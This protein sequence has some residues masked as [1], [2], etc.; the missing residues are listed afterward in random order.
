[1]KKVVQEIIKKC[2]SENLQGITLKIFRVTKN[3]LT[4]QLHELVKKDKS[5]EIWF[6]PVPSTHFE[7]SSHPKNNIFGPR[8]TLSFGRDLEFGIQLAQK[9]NVCVSLPIAHVSMHSLRSAQGQRQSERRGK[10]M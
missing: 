2:I 1:M 4:G 6:V 10:Q 8:K 7:L 3:F 5:V 9:I